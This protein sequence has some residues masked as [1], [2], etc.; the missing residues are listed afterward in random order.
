MNYAIVYSSST[1]NTKLLA[2]AIAAV[3]PKEDCVYMGAPDLSAIPQ[4]CKLI[5][6][7][8]WTDKGSCCTIIDPFLKVLQNKQLALFG[9]SG[10]GKSQEYFDK[11]LENVKEK[12]SKDCTVLDSF[13]CQGKMGMAVRTRY[14]TA[15][16]ESPADTKMQSLIDNFDEALSHPD[17]ADLTGVAAFAVGAYEKS[18]GLLQR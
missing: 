2:E 4:D 6:M 3:L 17:D 7:G 12:L 18:Q 14:E 13:M 8:F 5:F 15:L 1:G 16:N 9:T 11:I 10:F